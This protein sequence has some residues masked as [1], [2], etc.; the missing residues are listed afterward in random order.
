MIASEREREAQLIGEELKR[1]R[2]VEAFIARVP[3]QA[4]QTILRRRYLD[5]GKSWDEIRDDLARDG[6]LYSPRHLQR[7]HTQAL[8]AAQMLWDEEAGRERR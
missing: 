6:V 4:Q 3:Q 8:R 7:L 1:Y 5:I 2:C